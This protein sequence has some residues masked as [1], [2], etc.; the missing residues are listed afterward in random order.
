M[1][2]TIKALLKQFF[3]AKYE[4]GGK[5]LAAA[6]ILFMAVY[7]TGF[8]LAV[9]PFIFYLTSVFF[10]AGIMWQ[11][12]AGRRHMETLQ[13]MFMLPFDNRSFVFSY[14]LV[15][16][17]H[18]LMTKTLLIWGLFIAA[19]SWSPWEIAVAIACGC[20]A[21][22]VTA[23]GYGMHRKGHDVLPILW[24]AGI[25]AIILLVRQRVAVLIAAVISVIAAVLYL[26]F[27]D[28]YDFYSAGTAKKAIRHTGRTGDVF[29]Y[30]TRC[31]MANKTYLI[32]TAGLCGIACFLPLLF[33]EFGGFNMFPFGLAILSINT[34]ICTLL[35]CDPDLEQAIRMLPGQAGRFWRKFCLFIFTVN[36]IVSGIYLL[37]WQIVSGGMDFVHVGTLL[38]FAM[39]SA[40]LSVIL[41]WKYPIRGWKTES[42]LWHHPRKYLVP[43]IMLLTAAFAAT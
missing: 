2:N 24:N 12:L 5:S 21:C 10:T 13:G 11:V 6:V 18:T 28:A 7:G 36:S 33:G 41:E 30:L 39:Q 31:L 23:A 35:S 38:I 42:D 20:M 14:V 40:I 25:L 43:L 4:S 16:G 29:T 32:N 1:K 27:A 34:P 26:A 9:A 22:V 17:A 19:A 37:S 3:G 8:R 15:I